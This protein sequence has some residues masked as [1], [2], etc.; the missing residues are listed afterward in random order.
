[1]LKFF[2]KNIAEKSDEE[3]VLLYQRGGD[4]EVLGT[5][6][7]RYVEL[8]YGVSLKFFKEKTK[9]EDAVMAIFETLVEK[10]RTQEIRQ[11]RP[12]LHVVAKNHC[13]MQLRKKNHTISFDEMTPATQAEVV[14]SAGVLHPV[15]VL[16]DE[17]QQV[18]LKNCIEKLPE[19][20]RHCVEQFYYEDKSY[21]EIADMNGEALGLV[22][23]NIQNGRRNLRICLEKSGVRTSSDW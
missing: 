16:E 15:D 3:L 5:L 2:R 9:S 19:Q 21:K 8:V 13:L 23:S 1:M 17:P 22:R 7:E 11:F 20:Q 10:V 18:A 6:Y 12:W 14:Y 4:L